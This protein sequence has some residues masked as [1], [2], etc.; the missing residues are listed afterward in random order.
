MYVCV[1]IHSRFV[2]IE[3]YNTSRFPNKKTTDLEL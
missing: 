3:F 1:Y 2:N